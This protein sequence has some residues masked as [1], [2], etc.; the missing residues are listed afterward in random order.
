MLQLIDDDRMQ[1]KYYV[2]FRR[3]FK[4]CIKYN[5]SDLRETPCIYERLQ[6]MHLFTFLFIVNRGYIIYSLSLSPRYMTCISYAKYRKRT[7]VYL[8]DMYITIL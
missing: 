1:S 5:M 4:L 2:V 8:N 3:M 7:I 6:H